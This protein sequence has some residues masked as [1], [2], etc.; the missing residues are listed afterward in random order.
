MRRGLVRSTSSCN[1]PQR[2]GVRPNWGSQNVAAL[3]KTL[4]QPTVRRRR[5]AGGEYDPDI[6]T[7]TYGTVTDVWS[8]LEAMHRKVGMK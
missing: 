7:V 5:R 4:N 1:I 6:R 3:D 8:K 2:R